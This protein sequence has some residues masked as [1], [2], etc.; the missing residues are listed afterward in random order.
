MLKKANYPRISQK[1]RLHLLLLIFNWLY[2][3]FISDSASTD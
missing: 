3:S 1:S 2:F